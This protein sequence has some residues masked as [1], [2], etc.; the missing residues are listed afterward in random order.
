MLM[1]RRSVCHSLLLSPFAG[2]LAAADPAVV[3][4]TPVQTEAINKTNKT[5]LIVGLPGASLKSPPGSSAVPSDVTGN[6]N[7]SFPQTINV[8]EGTKVKKKPFASM[9]IDE[10]F[11]T[12]GGARTLGNSQLIVKLVV[13]GHHPIAFFDSGPSVTK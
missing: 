12:D 11:I 5:F 9:V 10:N 13:S 3:S 2:I 7:M 4:G 1:S 8:Y 6:L